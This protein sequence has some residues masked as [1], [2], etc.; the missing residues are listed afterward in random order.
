MNVLLPFERRILTAVGASLDEPMR[1]LFD[2]QLQCIN[3]V[4]RL[5][6]WNEI[7]FYCMS[8]FKVRWPEAVLFQNKAEFVLGSGQLSADDET[9]QI[10]VWSVGGHV[11]SIES[12]T[13]LKPFRNVASVSFTLSP[14]A[15]QQAAAPDAIKRAGERQRWAAT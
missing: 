14:N 13:S 8:W 12:K 15:A 1:L 11:F 5:L 3:K 10:H 2:R 6:A 9:A 7:E 4:Q